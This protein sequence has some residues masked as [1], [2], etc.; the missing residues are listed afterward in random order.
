MSGT[1]AVAGQRITAA[2]LNLNI[3][4][5]WVAVTPTNG[6]TNSGTGL[7][8][9]QAR[10]FNSV[11]VEIVAD[12]TAGT[13]TAGTVL[14]TWSSALGYPATNQSGSAQIMQGTNFGQAVA[15]GL[16]SIGQVAIVG[17]IASGD[18]INF[19]CFVPLDA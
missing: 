11:T 3:P 5:P 2:W 19:H 6:W 4:G 14:G 13:V 15:L 9:F 10:K 12:I 8:N 17:S 18:R 16:N 7:P 1:L